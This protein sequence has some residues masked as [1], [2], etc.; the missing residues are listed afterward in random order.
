MAHRSNQGREH[1]G[2]APPPPTLFSSL[3]FCFGVCE[4]HQAFAWG[5]GGWGEGPC[6]GSERDRVDT[7]EAGSVRAAVCQGGGE[8]LC[9][10]PHV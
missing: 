9:R 2:H 10:G 5:V 4:V 8:V 3:L 1:A 6:F 7:G